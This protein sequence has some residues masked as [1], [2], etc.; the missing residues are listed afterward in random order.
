MR[1]PRALAV[2][3]ASLMVLAVAGTLALPQGGRAA[4]ARSSVAYRHG[5]P[6]GLPAL[7][8]TSTGGRLI[9]PA[10]GSYTADSLTP[11]TTPPS[12]QATPAPSGAPQSLPV[13]TTGNLPSLP[14][15]GTPITADAIVMFRSPLSQTDETTLDHLKGI[16]ATTVVDTGTVELAGAPAVTFG[17]DPQS[18]RWFTPPSS[19]TVVRLWQ[20]LAGGSLV[21]SYDMATD[22]KLQLGV[23]DSVTPAT[24]GAAV[25]GWMGAFASLGLPGVDLLVD[26]QF[27]P[28]LGLAPRT[29]AV[30]SAPTLNGPT[31]QNE[32]VRALPG[33]TVELLRLAQ[34]PDITGN[35]LNNSQRAAIVAAALSRVGRPYVWGG[36]GPDVFDCSGLVK[37]AYAQAGILMP[38][39]AAE[40][41]LTGEHIGLAQA[42]PGDLLFWTYDP[43]DPTFVDHVAIYLGNGMMVVAPHAG[44]DVEVVPVPTD[45]MAG[46]V[47]VVLQ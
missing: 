27:S 14:S 45:H 7:R 41:F 31:L 39:T 38:R 23:L 32:I 3:V 37:W 44:L 12:V 36:N 43:N 20:Y 29:A 13:P 40:Q 11:P 22:R 25:Q 33:A 15:S 47:R 9:A 19:A 28:E 35:S 34:I 18:F 10:T 26:R 46:V 6:N 4:G 5:I 30:V 2:C 8:S 42:A 24:G 21:S 16:A 17:V 1:L